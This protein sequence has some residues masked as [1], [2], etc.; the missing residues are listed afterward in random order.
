VAT[1]VNGETW[2]GVLRTAAI[3]LVLSAALAII[4]QTLYVLSFPGGS[5]ETQ[6]ELISQIANPAVSV[7]LLVAVLLLLARLRATDPDGVP[8]R[9]DWLAVAVIVLGAV[10]VLAAVY[11]MI[12]LVSVHVPSPGA[13]G[14]DVQLRVTTEDWLGRL[15]Q[16]LLRV[17]GGILGAWAAWMAIANVVVPSRAIRRASV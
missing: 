14:Q 11:S 17:S 8:A 2:N 13:T 1:V 12:H 5:T 7:L 9:S 4:G 15:G 16:I 6:L 3:A 10:I